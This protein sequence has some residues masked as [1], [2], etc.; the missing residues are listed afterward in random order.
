MICRRK[1]GNLLKDIDWSLEGDKLRRFTK[2]IMDLKKYFH[3]YF[4]S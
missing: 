3:S 2:Y 1:V 4:N